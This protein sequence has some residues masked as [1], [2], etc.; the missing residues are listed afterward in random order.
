VY[1][2]GDAI[3]RAPPLKRISDAIGAALGPEVV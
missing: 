1:R 3:V 2:D